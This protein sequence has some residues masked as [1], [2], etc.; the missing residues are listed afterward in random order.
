MHPTVTDLKPVTD[1]RRRFPAWGLA[2]FVLPAVGLTLAWCAFEY[3]EHVADDALR[4]SMHAVTALWI[5][6]ATVLCGL[7]SAFIG[8][9]RRERFW[10]LAL[11]AL[12]LLALPCSYIL[13]R[14]VWG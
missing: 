12:I 5:L 10:A 4:E 7:V 11:A 9:W 2:A 1:T 3:D 6:P 14:L 8:V 13:L